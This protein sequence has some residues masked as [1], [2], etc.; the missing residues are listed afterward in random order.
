MGACFAVGQKIATELSEI[1][2][3]LNESGNLTRNRWSFNG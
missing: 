1:P 3:S 2:E